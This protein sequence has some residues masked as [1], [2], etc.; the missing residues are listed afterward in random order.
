[1]ESLSRPF[2]LQASLELVVLVLKCSKFL[3]QQSTAHMPAKAAA[4]FRKQGCIIKM[5]FILST[6]APSHELRHRVALSMRQDS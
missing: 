4:T 3:S 1:M 2:F 5:S 6:F